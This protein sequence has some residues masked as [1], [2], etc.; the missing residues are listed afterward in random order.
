MSQIT[1]TNVNNIQFGILSNDDIEKMSVCEINKP[2]LAI[3]EG[4][5]YDPR[6]GCVDNESL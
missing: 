2:T 3:E 4:S 5:V 1:T 6:L